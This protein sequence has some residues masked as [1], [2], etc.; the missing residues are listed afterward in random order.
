MKTMKTNETKK[1]QRRTI[2]GFKPKRIYVLNSMREHPIAQRILQAYP[3]AE[4]I[5]TDSQEI[6]KSGKAQFET[7]ED[8]KATLFLGRSSRFVAETDRNE[9]CKGLRK[10]TIIQNGCHFS[11]EYCFLQGTY[12]ARWPSIK[13]NLNHEDLMKELERDIRKNGRALYNVG[14]NQ[15]SLAFDSL[16]PISQILVP[17]F[18]G[19]DAYLLMLTKSNC[20]DGLLDLDH[21]GHTIVS[22]S[23]NSEQVTSGYEHGAATLDERI[24]AAIAVQQAGYRLRYRFDPLLPLDGWQ[25]H[26][27]DMVKKVLSRT[28]P[29]RITLGSLRFAPVVRSISQKR[30]PGSTLFSNEG[31]EESRGEDHK[32]RLDNGV[33]RKLYEF[34]IREI[35]AVMG[36]DIEIALCKETNPMRESVGLT[37]N[38]NGCKCHCSL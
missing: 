25:D 1:Q 4:H 2:E 32:Y 13:F 27:S 17:F 16:Y 3:E 24:E 33:R 21:Q 35:R 12:R 29:E 10:I 14:E 9:L 34:V 19:K 7:V 15:D 5:F 8:S 37:P 18:A 36:A 22:W 30:F 26:Y 28:K 38:T 23:I 6:P 31:I 20:V 11:C